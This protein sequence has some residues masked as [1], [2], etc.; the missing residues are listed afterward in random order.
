MRFP[1]KNRFEKTSS[2]TLILIVICLGIFVAALDQTVVYGALPG[3]MVDIQLPVTKLDQASWIVIG[4]FLGYTFAMPLMGQVSDRYGHSR[5]YVLS[6]IIFMAGSILVALSA[7]LQWMVGA[8]VIQA[9][10]GGAVVPIAMAI[11]GDLYV[12]KN[13]AVALGIIGAA[14]EAGGALGPFYGAVLAQFWGWR[15]IFWINLPLAFI[16]IIVIALLLKPSP[17]TGGKIDY[18]DGFLLAAGLALL[19][20]GLS[21]QPGQAHFWTYMPIFIIAA[22]ILFT[23]FVVRIRRVDQPLINLSMFRNLTFSMANVTNFL[24]GGALIIAMVNIPVMSD[25]I[26]GTSPLEGGLRLLRFT[27]LLSIGAVAGGF[28]TKRFGYRVPTILGLILSAAGFFLMSR[29]TLT[30]ADPQMTIDLAVCGFGFGLVIAPLGT[31]VIDSAAEQHRG[32]ASS[33]VVMMRMTGMI[34][35]LAAITSWGMEHFHLLTAGMSLSEIVNTPEK[36][37]QSLLTIFHGFFLASIGICLVAIVP[38]VWLGREKT[39]H[40]QFTSKQ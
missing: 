13:R 11:V 8:R 9:I 33:L 35:G 24:V 12:G 2:P 40:Y 14:V 29:W 7:N 1:I 23:I 36:L 20:M 34:V 19:S 16:I 27:A 17:R 38:A 15:W 26:L 37:S 18:V 22:L 25:T 3:M 4:Y 39:T 6:L 32:I 5:I 28:L 10:G 21:Q 30:I 31:A